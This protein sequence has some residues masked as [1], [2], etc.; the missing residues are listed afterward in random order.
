MK[1]ILSLLIKTTSILIIIS[2]FLLF[3]AGI[4]SSQEQ[5]NEEGLRQKEGIFAPHTIRGEVTAVDS[6][7]IV[8]KTNTGDFEEVKLT[9][10]TC[11]VKELNVAKDQ[12]KIGE[13]LLV[14]GGFFKQ[15]T[16]NARLIKI[17]KTRDDPVRRPKF[18]GR[19]FSRH[20]R[21]ESRE[22]RKQY[23]IIGEITELEPLTIKGDTGLKR[24]IRITNKTEI[25]KES[26]VEHS[27]II[28]GKKVTIITR[29]IPHTNKREGIKVIAAVEKEGVLKK[30]SDPFLKTVSSNEGVN[31]LPKKFTVE[32]V[33]VSN[34]LTDI[35][36]VSASSEFI[37]GM[38]LG[39]GLYSNEELDRAFRVAHNLGIKHF[40]IEFKWGYVEP[41]NDKWDWT[42]EKTIDVEHVIKLARYYNISIIPYLDTFMPWGE[43]KK[44]NPNRGECLGPPSRWGQY[45]APDPKEY[46]D[47]AFKVVDKLK[48]SGVA[49]K[50]VELDNE[51]SNINDGYQSWNCFINVTAKQIKEFE[52][53][54]Y[55]RI[56]SVYPDI[57]ISSTT[58]SFPGLPHRLYE[59]FI[60]DNIRRNSFIRAY[61]EDEPKPEFDFLGIHEVLMGSGSPYTMAKK[62]E[63]ADYEYN[64]GSYHDA[65]DIWREILDKYGF[66]NKP[67]FNLECAAVRKGIQ[68]AQLLQRVVFARTNAKKNRVMGWVLSQLTGSKRFRKGKGKKRSV[69]GITELDQGYHLKEGYYAYYTLMTT[70]ACYPNYEGR[71]MGELNTHKPLIE[72]FRSDANRVLYIAF[73]PYHMKL[74]KALKFSLFVGS[75]KEIKVTKSNGVSFVTESNKE[76]FIS[77][78][79]DKKPIFIEVN[80]G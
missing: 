16:L 78:N 31:G 19:K 74:E 45:Q 26:E 37:Y 11:Y 2:T 23:P 49:V 51:V 1:S 50:Y 27:E 38:W 59:N 7:A 25:I 52:N 15:D 13:K 65:Y 33:D 44:L 41:E 56:K 10:R 12:L 55:N 14:I 28:K 40:M 20:K 61:F 80:E 46:A 47:Y 4:L 35:S 58:F 76:G 48:R 66:N 34:L 18:M 75:S 36:R 63:N 17:I 22:S 42:N 72:K 8:V 29:S 30:G 3:H 5:G 62:P 60:E 9:Q 43:R 57:M 68:D 53:N 69:I 67:I 77:F 6:N 71:V 70:L 54:A 73:I 24:T 64:F 32:D 79:I 39:R 21:F